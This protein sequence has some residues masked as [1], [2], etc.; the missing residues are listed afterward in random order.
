MGIIY[1]TR[2]INL[3]SQTIKRLISIDYVL[4][5]L[6]I[7]KKSLT[8]KIT[9]RAVAL[10]PVNKSL[11]VNHGAGSWLGY[12]Y[13]VHRSR[14]VIASETSHE[15]RVLAPDGVDSMSHGP[16]IQWRKEPVSE[17]YQSCI[18][19]SNGALSRT[20]MFIVTESETIAL[21]MS[22]ILVHNFNVKKQA[23]KVGSKALPN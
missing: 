6:T 18:L 12:C 3:T 23:S 17:K 10:E 7:V 4:L 14:H 13:T 5:E 11:H 16:R 2:L 20:L 15:K 22:N 21:T 1:K 8:T 19:T 9:A